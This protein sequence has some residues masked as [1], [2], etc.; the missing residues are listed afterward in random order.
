MKKATIFFIL[1]LLFTAIYSCM[2]PSSMLNDPSLKLS[3]RLSALNGGNKAMLVPIDEGY[4][5]PAGSD[6]DTVETP[7]ILGPQLTNPY[8]LDNMT[9]AYNIVHSANISRLTPTNL[10]VRFLPSDLDQLALLADSLDLDLFDTPMD[11]SL[12][13][14]G[15]YYQDPSMPMEQITWQYAVVQ[16]GFQFPTGV[17]YQILDSIY[18]PGNDDY[19]VEDMAFQ[20][21]GEPDIDNPP[22]APMANIAPYS[23][24]FSVGVTPQ[25]LQ[26]PPGYHWDF[27]HMSGCVP[28]NC[29]PGMHWDPI[30]KKCVEDTP[31]PPP[32]PPPGP[33]AHY[34]AGH[35]YVHDTNL[36][37]PNNPNDGEPLR[38]ARVVAKRWFKIQR[39]YTDDN[40]YFE[41][42]IRFHKKAKIIVKFK[43]DYST[44]RGAVGL[45][46]WQMLFPVKK[47][48]GTYSGTLNNIHY[49]FQHYNTTTKAL[50]NRDWVAATINNAIQ[51]HRNYA[52][53]FGFATAP[54]KLRI[55]ITP[56]ARF[57]GLSSAP[58]F[59][60][61]FIHDLPLSFAN[62]FLVGLAGT[63]AG[64]VNAFIAV[65]TRTQLDIA[66]GYHYEDMNWFT[67]DVIKESTYHEL[68]HA[69]D[70]SRVGDGWYTSFVK[71]ELAEIEAHPSASDPLNPYG[72]ATSSNAPIIAL[73]EAWGY[74][75][76]HFLADQRYGYHSSPQY[77]QQMWY[78][79]NSPIS[80]LSSHLNLL[81]NFDPNNINDPFHWIPQGLMYDLMDIGNE[82]IPVIDNVSGF[83]IQQL[84]SPLQSDVYTLQQYKDR[85]Q[86]Q[87]P[88][89][90]TTQITDLFAQYGY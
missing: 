85:L 36:N 13:Q 30:L 27:E 16:P 88:G 89:N 12:V 1:V 3:G 52:S 21:T 2:K 9:V 7:T 73:G 8:S 76:G 46:L 20:L 65:V 78:Y 57:D 58:L 49:T 82:G 38:R 63:I 10:Y 53:Q 77:Q 31:P 84:F 59:G 69:S 41:S 83:T 26:C 29:G 87:N 14:D 90:Q 32:P 39:L 66:I 35:L 75:M 42:I 54:M 34:P 64:G 25:V 72:P 56:W 86:Q 45:R 50:G 81:E 47:N 11:Y 61:R 23:I 6:L 60:K 15:D 68:S 71:A 62:T 24:P 17:T 74:H 51:E 43:N 55:Y 33:G 70:Y 19:Q 37:D 40:G 67:S 28:D 4:I 18:I 22:M 5:P 80:G 48:L 79:N 44:I